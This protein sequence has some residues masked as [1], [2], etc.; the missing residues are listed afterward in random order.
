M[1]VELAE[2]AVNCRAVVEKAVAA[3]QVKVEQVA[4][5]GIERK[6]PRIRQTIPTLLTVAVHTSCQNS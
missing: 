1:V 4:G 2:V 5:R 3:G 6:I